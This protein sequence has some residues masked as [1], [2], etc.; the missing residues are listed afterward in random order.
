MAFVTSN[1][2]IPDLEHE[3]HT[4]SIDSM[5]QASSNSFTCFLNRSIKNVVQARLLAAHI[6]T[7]KNTEHIYISIE[8]LDT[9]FN[10]RAS[11]VFNG[12]SDLTKLNGC[13]ASVISTSVS[14]GNGNHVELFRDEYP[15]VTQYIDPIR[16]LSR[17][18]VKIYD[19]SGDP[20]DPG[21]H[22]EPNHMII[23]F[24][25]RKPNL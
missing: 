5:G 14:H 15:I 23:R 22:D 25:C 20:L 18:T 4:V 13:F 10:V 17:F 1:S 8:E 19:E 9:N 2:V 3:Y 11:N 7:R 21:T 16:Q 12:Q 24:V 6:H